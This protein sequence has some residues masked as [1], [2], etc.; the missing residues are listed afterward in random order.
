MR[1][2][3]ALVVTAAVA[4]LL[5]VSCASQKNVDQQTFDKAPLFGMVY[6]EDNQPC[7]GVYLTVDSQPGPVTDI[8]GRFVVSDLARGDHRIV[9]NKAG[10]EA[11]SASVTF[12]NRTDVLHLTIVSFSQL[13]GMAEKSLSDLKWEDARGFLKRAEALDPGDAVLHYLYAVVAYRTGDYPGAVIFLKAILDGPTP[14]SPA[15]YLFLADLYQDKLSD[16]PNAIASLAS[17][18]KLRADP[19]VE[20]RLAALKD[21]QPAGQAPP[22]G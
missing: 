7:S 13:L 18:L 1:R 6:D 8:R 11:L 5:A 21:A 14:P 22:P 19:D 16:A 15:V 17:Y 10:Y 4:A 9:A 12:L 2:P 20:K 3:A